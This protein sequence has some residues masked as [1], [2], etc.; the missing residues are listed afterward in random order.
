M[1][2]FCM[3]VPIL[4]N[5]EEYVGA[6]C[7]LPFFKKEVSKFCC[8]LVLGHPVWIKTTFVKDP[9]FIVSFP[10]VLYSVGWP[11]T[12]LEC[13]VWRYC[14][15]QGRPGWIN[16]S[17]FMKPH[18]TFFQGPLLTVCWLGV[19][20]KSWHGDGGRFMKCVMHWVLLVTLYQEVYAVYCSFLRPLLSF[21]SLLPFLPF[22]FPPLLFF[23]YFSFPL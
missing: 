12:R 1:N 22:P 8:S 19:G 11:D 4:L 13:W 17:K 2:C 6:L 20:T 7:S 16:K 5:P 14:W 3:I 18:N 15:G 10:I 21:L 23:C 9:Q